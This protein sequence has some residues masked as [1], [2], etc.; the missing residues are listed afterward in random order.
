[1]SHSTLVIIRWGLLAAAA[2]SVLQATL[3]QAAFQRWIFQP[4]LMLNERAGARV[5]LIVRSAR[6]HRTWPLFMAFLFLALWWYL[7]TPDGVAF[8]SRAAR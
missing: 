5:P 8:F 2:L 6:M 4:W 7:G 3:L 1:M